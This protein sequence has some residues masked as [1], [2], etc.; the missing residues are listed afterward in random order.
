MFHTLKILNK[1]VLLPTKVRIAQKYL[2]NIF[3]SLCIRC[4]DDKRFIFILFHE[5]IMVICNAI[6]DSIFSFKNRTEENYSVN[7]YLKMYDPDKNTW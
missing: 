6:Y 4:T 7:S 1:N 2:T 5:H 3:S